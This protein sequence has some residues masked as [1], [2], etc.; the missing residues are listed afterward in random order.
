MTIRKHKGKWQVISSTKGVIG[1]HR[2]KKEA[3]RQHRAVM[4][5]K[6]RKGKKRK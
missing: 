4:A 5:S 3:L 6:A 1:T 2:T